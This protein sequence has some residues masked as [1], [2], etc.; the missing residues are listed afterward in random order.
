MVVRDSPGT[1]CEINYEI[2]RVTENSRG[3]DPEL[4][5]WQPECRVVVFANGD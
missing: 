1:S 2:E 5:P 3:E 4:E